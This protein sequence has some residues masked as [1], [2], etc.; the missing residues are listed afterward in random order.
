NCPVGITSQKEALRKRFNGSPEPVIEFFLLIAEEVRHTLAKL[1]YHSLSE[2]IGRS[3]LLRARNGLTLPKTTELDVTCLL[4]KDGSDQFRYEPPRAN[5]S[6]E[7]SL[8][9]AVI[10]DSEIANAIESH[11]HASKT[12]PIKNTD[13]AVGARLSGVLAK[14]YGDYGF[15]GQI[16]L[17]FHG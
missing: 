13:R 5:H 8:D 3:D 16:N 1:G 9:W 11:S 12:L 14:K 17:T 6:H 10:S 4:A 7:E 2:V 15:R